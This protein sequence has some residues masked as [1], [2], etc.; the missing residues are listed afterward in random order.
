[1]NFGELLHI[2][3][4]GYKM[5]AH[6]AVFSIKKGLFRKTSMG[7][8]RGLNFPRQLYYRTS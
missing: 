4:I 6:A 8:K 5:F 1:M 2:N 7:D 3:L